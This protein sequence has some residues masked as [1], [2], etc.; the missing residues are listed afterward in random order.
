MSFPFSGV[1]CANVLQK[2][3]AP[4]G[5]YPAA[6]LFS[7]AHFVLLLIS[8][9][10]IAVGYLSLRE[11]PEQRLRFVT[12]IVAIVVT[13]LEVIK[14]AFEL[15]V[16]RKPISHLDSWLP[17]FFCSL[18]LYYAWAS[19]SRSPLLRRFGDAFLSTGAVV[20]GFFF[21]L[22]PSTSLTLVPAWH[23]LGIY[24]MLY[25]SLMVIFG[26]LYMRY[27]RLTLEHF[28][29]FAWS[30]MIFVIP[31]ILLNQTVGCNAMMLREPFG[32]PS[33][34][35]AIYDFSHLLYSA[36]VMVCYTVFPFFFVGLIDGLFHRF[37]AKRAIRRDAADRDGDA[38]AQKR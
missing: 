4:E 18:F 7:R 1:T 23:Y 15:L 35:F 22:V 32:L 28:V 30:F 26:L 31:A 2:I 21:L 12:R 19:S 10:F 25:H 20:G 3:F 5:E 27:F 11:L 38:R 6:G 14:I 13:V 24:S 9:A 17:L 34:V 33:I 37:K 16:S 8:F 29:T 36:L